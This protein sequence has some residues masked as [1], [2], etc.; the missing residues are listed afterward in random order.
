MEPKTE[1][2]TV[3]SQQI[4]DNIV[5]AKTFDKSKLS[6]DVIT[7][8]N[9]NP[10]SGNNYHKKATMFLG[11]LYDNKP[12]LL[13]LAHTT[14]EEGFK[15]SNPNFPPSAK[16]RFLKPQCQ[17]L[18][19]IDNFINSVIHNA[20]RNCPAGTFASECK[21]DKFCTNM[22]TSPYSH[23]IVN[24]QNFGYISWPK[25]TNR[26]TGQDIRDIANPVNKP[27]DFFKGKPGKYTLMLE[28]NYLDVRRESG[29]DKA[30]VTPKWTLK[31]IG[32]ESTDNITVEIVAA[33]ADFGLQEDE[34]SEPEEVDGDE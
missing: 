2:K 13:Q 29:P 16:V 21:C 17:M 30:A 6:W 8:K 18:K 9:Y 23:M 32:L 4:P 10:N 3:F 24:G 20:P 12:L 14:V 5:T 26:I 15:E 25:D 22:K 27:L 7:N 34:D 33:V 28:F 31:F 1:I 11:L 19:D